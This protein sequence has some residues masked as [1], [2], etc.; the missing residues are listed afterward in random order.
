MNKL[1]QTSVAGLLAL[2]CGFAVAEDADHAGLNQSQQKC[3]SRA[4]VGLDSVINSRIGVPIEEAM[5][6]TRKIGDV[7]I[8]DQFDKSYLLPVLH[9]YMWLGSPHTYAIKV[10]SECTLEQNSNLTQAA[11]G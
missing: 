7:T 9:A 3:Y 11:A 10:F 2:A 1:P 4:M 6:I 5:E 8:S